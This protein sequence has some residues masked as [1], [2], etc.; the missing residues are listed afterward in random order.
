MVSSSS[1]SCFNAARL[2][3]S[4]TDAILKRPVTAKNCAR[5]PSRPV[6]AAARSRAL[7]PASIFSMVCFRR[8]ALGMVRACHRPGRLPG[9]GACPAAEP[10]RA[11]RESSGFM[12]EVEEPGA[13]KEILWQR[14]VVVMEPNEKTVQL[15]HC[16]GEIKA[17]G[18]RKTTPMSAETFNVDGSVVS[19]RRQVCNSSPSRA[20]ARSQVFELSLTQLS[21][22]CQRSIPSTTAWTN[23][24]V[25]VLQTSPDRVRLP[26]YQEIHA[27]E[28]LFC[29]TFVRPYLSVMPGSSATCQIGLR[30]T[31][32]SVFSRLNRFSGSAPR[33]VS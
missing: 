1:T 33:R 11:G 6:G 9:P 31:L 25:K 27:K 23:S 22:T 28:R 8:S 32:S 4:V 19:A 20:P 3:S 14:S 15:R 13:F 16:F 12:K 30:H 7:R 24:S 2:G 10:T 21:L 17:D 5:L 29:P 18:L 26:V